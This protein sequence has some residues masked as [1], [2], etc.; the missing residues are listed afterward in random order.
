MFHTIVSRIP[1]ILALVATLLIAGCG[2]G[3]GAA[4][5]LTDVGSGG[6]GGRVLGVA[7]GFGSLIVD[8][9][10]RDD[11]LA[12]YSSEEDQGPAMAMA[13]TGVMLGHSLELGYDANDRITSV[14]VSPELLGPVS[15]VGAN[16]VTVLGMN[17][18][19]NQDTTLG[20]VTALVGYAAPNAIQIGDRVAVYGL[21]KTDTQGAVSLQAT[22]IAQKPIGTGVRLTGY[23]SQYNASAN[24]FVI[25]G[26]TVAIGSAT[27][28]PAGA[29]LANGELVT[30]WSD[31]VPAGST[32]TASSIRIKMPASFNGNLTLSGAVSGY[33]SLADFKIRHVNIDASTATI[34]PSGAAVADSKYVIAVGRY[35][36]STNKL[37]ASSVTVYA[38]AAASAVELHGTVVN[39]VSASSFTVRGVV[40][41]ASSANVAGGSLDQLANGGF[42]EVIGA[43]VNNAVKA[44]TLVIVSLNPLNAPNGAMLDL[45]GT[46]TSFDATTGNYTM[47]MSSG[48]TLNGTMGSSMFYG[49]GTAANFAVGQP[50]SVRGMMKNNQLSTS[51][52]NFTQMA[53]MS[54]AGSAH[55]EGIIY[56]VT[57][58]SFMLNGLTI[59]R[60]GVPIQGGGGMMGGRSMMSGAR[61][62]VDVQYS[63]GQYKAT[64]ITLQ[65]G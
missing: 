62:G 43:V 32:I 10:R 58:S 3:G 22:L 29:A 45:G 47:T 6:T 53:P 2:G 17:V 11:S 20:P 5:L 39:F 19:I 25:G 30:V 18:T 57:A 61:V 34:S 26:N 9:M 51:V 31:T 8:G 38:P 44:S 59:Q 48:A 52:V 27:L 4:A 7:T 12:G 36:S 41:D 46:I 13:S 33:A 35:D 40:V 64:A 15:A 49:N 54:A 42:V 37:T 1:G 21:L 50:V 24:T 63:A 55:M 56:N 65:N 14:M 16:G 23:V 28:S 60:N